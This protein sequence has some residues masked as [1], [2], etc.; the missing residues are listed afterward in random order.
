MLQFMTG[1]G[2]PTGPPATLLE[3]HSFRHG[4]TS[5]QPAPANYALQELVRRQTR[6]QKRE[7]ASTV[8]R[9]GLIHKMRHAQRHGRIIREMGRMIN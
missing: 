1:P 8:L 2:R 3:A 4:Q 6:E 7:L 9:S 5:R